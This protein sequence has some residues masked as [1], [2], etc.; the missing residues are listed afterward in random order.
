MKII[1]IIILLIAVFLIAALASFQL[2]LMLVNAL[3]TKHAHPQ[4]G[5]LTST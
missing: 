3:F 4:Q 5:E 1:K 2:F